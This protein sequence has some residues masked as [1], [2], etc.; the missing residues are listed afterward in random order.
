MVL[1]QKGM[2]SR[3]SEENE[4][5]RQKIEIDK[6]KRLAACSKNG[7]CGERARTKGSHK[8]RLSKTGQFQYLLHFASQAH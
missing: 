8:L 2:Y 4:T 3:F 7:S 6:L 1:E 5:V